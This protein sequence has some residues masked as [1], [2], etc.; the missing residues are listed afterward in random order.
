MKVGDLVRFKAGA[1]A[2]VIKVSDDFGSYAVLYCADG[3]LDNTPS[4]DG[5][6]H[7]SLD[8]LKRTSEVISE[9]R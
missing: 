5:I 1:T 2:T 6:T 7:M 9:S 4:S 3:S 8:M